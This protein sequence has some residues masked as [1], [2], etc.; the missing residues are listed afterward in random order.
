MPPHVIHARMKQLAV[1]ER[2]LAVGYK[3]RFLGL[4]VEVLVEGA[5]PVS[6]T[7]AEGLTERYIKVRFPLRDGQK[8]HE[9]ENTLQNIRVTDI[10]APD[11][12]I[13]RIQ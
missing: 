2:E 5:A 13:G 8:V 9:V 7:I 1:L 10:P 4:D 12:V 11:V 6:E 3:K